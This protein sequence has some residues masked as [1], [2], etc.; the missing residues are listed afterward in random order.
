MI[1]KFRLPLLVGLLGLCLITLGIDF[2][3]KVNA[4]QNY[5]LGAA[6]TT[7]AGG[8]FPVLAIAFDGSTDYL[9]RGGGL[10]GAADTIYGIVSVWIKPGGNG[11]LGYI[12]RNTGGKHGSHRLDTNVFQFQMIDASSN[13]RVR[14]N[15]SA[16]LAASGWT[17]VLASWKGGTETHLYVN[18][19]EDNTQLDSVATATDNTVADWSIGGNT[20]GAGKYAGDMAELWYDHSQATFDA[21]GDFSVEAN[22]RKFIDVSGFPVDLEDTGAQPILHLSVRP[23]DSAGDFVTNRGTGGNFVDQGSIAVAGTSPSD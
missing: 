6:T 11:V 18:D 1:K 9:L 17:H 21:F 19:I 14:I 15:S 2:S 22:R 7:T 10:T 13:I 4:G 20:A 23:G 12:I 16:I 3:P 5:Y 8:D